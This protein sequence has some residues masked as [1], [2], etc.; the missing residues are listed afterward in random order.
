MDTV[1]MLGLCI[2]LRYIGCINTLAYNTYHIIHFSYTIFLHF[3]Y[4]ILPTITFLFKFMVFMSLKFPNSYAICAHIKFFGSKTKQNVSLI[5]IKYR[6]MCMTICIVS[7]KINILS[8]NIWCPLCA[9][10]DIPTQYLSTKHELKHVHVN[11]E[12]NILFSS[13]IQLSP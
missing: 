7:H 6:F 12:S 2:I 13:A 5:H 11:R 8:P 10:L 1:Y 4:I 3:S 9:I